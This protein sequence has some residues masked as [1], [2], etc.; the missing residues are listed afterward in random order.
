MVQITN[1]NSEMTGLIEVVR[2][3]QIT[4]G[5]YKFYTNNNVNSKLNRLTQITGGNSEI[6]GLKQITDAIRTKK[7][8]MQK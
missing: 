8:L 5:T 3:T 6:I 4:V 2:I 1:V 7:R